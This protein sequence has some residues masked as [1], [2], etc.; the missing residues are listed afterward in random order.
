MGSSHF[1]IEGSLRIFREILRKLVADVDTTIV[2]QAPDVALGAATGSF[3][4]GISLCLISID[5]GVALG[6]RLNSEVPEVVVC[7]SHD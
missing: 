4:D 3:V 1:S 7:G 6:A 5:V 2:G